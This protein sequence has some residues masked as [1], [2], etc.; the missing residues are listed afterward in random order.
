[1]SRHDEP[2]VTAENNASVVRLA[3]PG[4]ALHHRVKHGLDIRRGSRDHAQ[5]LARGG[6]L[7]QGLGQLGVARLELLEQAHVLD[8]DHGLIG[9]GLKEGDLSL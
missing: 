5:D 4:R 3:Q 1:M 7:R 6:L 2:I 8:G 9:E